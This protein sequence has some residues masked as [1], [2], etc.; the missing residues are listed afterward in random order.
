ML[1]KQSV[2]TT[3]IFKTRSIFPAPDY[4]VDYK[5]IDKDTHT[6]AQIHFLGSSN[7]TIKERQ[8]SS[9]KQ[10]QWDRD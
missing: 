10:L 1:A 3:T 2:Q 8:D 5:I 6:H 9:L 4:T 7:N